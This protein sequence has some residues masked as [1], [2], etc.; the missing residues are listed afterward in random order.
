[1]YRYRFRGWDGLG[2]LRGYG[3]RCLAGQR[4]NQ[5][6]NALVAQVTQCR[7]SLTIAKTRGFRGVA[8][9]GLHKRILRRR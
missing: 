5:L 4:L 9:V 8:V 7:L 6:T 2:S 3:G 1:M